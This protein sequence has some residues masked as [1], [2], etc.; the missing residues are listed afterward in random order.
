V[1]VEDVPLAAQKRRHARLEDGL[2]LF[3]RDLKFGR[4]KVAPQVA[5]AADERE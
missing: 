3:G 4:R 2:A 5:V 1:V